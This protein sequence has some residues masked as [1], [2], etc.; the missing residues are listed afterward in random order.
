MA[1]ARLDQEIAGT[2]ITQ[3]RAKALPAVSA[4]AS[5]TRLDEVQKMQL[6]DQA[7]E[8]GT[9]DNYAVQAG[10]SQLLYSGGKVNAALRAARL[11]QEY[12]LQART[13]AEQEL[14]RDI[15]KGFYGILLAESGVRVRQQT[16]AQMADLLEQ[17]EV[18][19]RSG[20][21]SEYDVLSVRVQL[22]NER[23]ALYA[24]SNALAM[25]ECQFRHTLGLA[26]DAPLRLKGRLTEQSVRLDVAR[27]IDA[28]LQRRPV[29]VALEIAGRL[30]AQ[31]VIAARAEQQPAVRAGFSYNG[32][33]SYRFATYSDDWQWHWNANLA[34]TWNLWDGG[35][36][37]GT[38]RQKE[39]ERR[40]AQTDLEDFRGL[41]RLEIRQAVLDAVQ[42]QSA[43]EAGRSSEEE[44]VK[45]LEIVRSRYDQGL[46]T[47]MECTESAVALSTARW[48]RLQAIHD[49]LQALAEVQCAAGLDDKEFAE[50]CATES[51]GTKQDQ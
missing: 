23:P 29:L 3:E 26:D 20:A 13:E 49:F 45:A 47:Q 11:T 44:A 38:I 17:A 16:L 21:A 2:R 24:A 48:L 18:R 25:A 35:L 33:N 1:Q 19:F 40:K 22:A 39:L 37:V 46:A 27:L 6:G 9:L 15:R 8:A 31:D 28:G 32:A 36:T 41:V 5:Y 7:V 43:I 51:A 50:L 34:A 30:K 10:V 14:V 12:A 42:A 4:D